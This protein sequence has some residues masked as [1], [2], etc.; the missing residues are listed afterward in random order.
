MNTKVHIDM[1]SIPWGDKNELLQI[2]MEL[3]ISDLTKLEVKY[4]KLQR[5]HEA[6]K[7]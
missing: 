2:A 6:V 5:A 7:Q 3:N 4:N 1:R